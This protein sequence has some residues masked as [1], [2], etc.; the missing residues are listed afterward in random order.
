MCWIEREASVTLTDKQRLALQEYVF[1]C[2]MSNMFG[3]GMEADYIRDGFPAFK[4]ISH[5]TDDEL[6]EEA[7]CQSDPEEIQRF[8]TALET[9]TE[10]EEDDEDEEC[11]HP[12]N[13]NQTPDGMVCLDC[14]KVVLG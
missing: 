12:G 2:C 5:M 8:L 14:M 10:E 9:P 13:F 1:D 4:G 6:L 11:D 3:D 7:G